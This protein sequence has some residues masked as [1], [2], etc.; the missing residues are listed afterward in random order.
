MEEDERWKRIKVKVCG[1]DRRRRY[2][3]DRKLLWK[4]VVV[5]SDLRAVENEV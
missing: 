3:G 4:E 5:V 2:M 1:V